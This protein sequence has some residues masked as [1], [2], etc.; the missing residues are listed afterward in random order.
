MTT[1]RA[2]MAVLFLLAVLPSALRADEPTPEP[3]TEKRKLDLKAPDIRKIFSPEQIDAVLSEAKDPTLEHIEVEAL[4]L[5]DLPQRDTGDPAAERILRRGL[6][7][8][9]PRENRVSRPPDATS[10]DRPP[11]PMHSNDLPGTPRPPH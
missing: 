8:I 3:A 2:E 5:D 10:P 9:A 6:S 1:I 4:P 11:P 7:W